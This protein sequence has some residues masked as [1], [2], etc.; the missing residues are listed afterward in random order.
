MGDFL[1]HA[2]TFARIEDR[3]KRFGESL[4]PLV[5]SDDRSFTRPWGGQGNPDGEIEVVYATQDS[6]FSPAARDFFRYLIEAP[7]IGWFQSSAAGLDNPAFRPVGLKAG[8]FTSAHEQSPAIAEWVLRAGLDHFQGGPARRTAQAEERWD[9]TP[10]RELCETRWVIV[11]FGHIGRQTAR[12]LRGLGAHVTGVRRSPGPDEDADA[13]LSPD[14]MHAALG[15]ADG[16]LLCLPL[17]PETQKMADAAFFAA[18]QP[19]ALFLNVGRGK[20]V[21]EEALLAGL[22]AGRPGHAS[23][24]V[25]ATEP[26]PA[27]NPIWQHPQ[28]SLTPHISALTEAAKQRTDTLFLTNLEAYLSGGPLKNLIEKSVFEAM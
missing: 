5:V 6:Y 15:E 1:C 16:V 27:G 8:A 13:I 12:L 28:I 10:F 25:V 26:L 2:A 18:M 3:L 7:R 20:L 4:S 19:G 22:D 23:L 14:R 24:D 21:D 9:R 11:G 17:S